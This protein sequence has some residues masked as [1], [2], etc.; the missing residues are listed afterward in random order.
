VCD[1]TSKGAC[2]VPRS[3]VPSDIGPSQVPHHSATSWASHWHG[4]HN[5]ADKILH[6][7]QGDESEDE[8]EDEEDSASSRSPAEVIDEDSESEVIRQT[9]SSNRRVK[10]PARMHATPKRATSFPSLTSNIYDPS[11]TTDTDEADMG[12]IGSSFTPADWRILARYIARTPGWKDMASRDR[13][14]G[15]LEKVSSVIFL[16]LGSEDLIV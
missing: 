11:A 2:S 13:W 4:R 6:S 15:F 16:I 7:F 3:N 12:P 1:V 14:D 9:T 10:P 5:I 8:E